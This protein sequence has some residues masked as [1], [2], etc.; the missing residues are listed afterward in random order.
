V[1]VPSRIRIR[2]SGKL[3]SR[4]VDVR[5]EGPLAGG[6]L[7]RDGRPQPACKLLA[8]L[9]ASASA[10]AL[11]ASGGHASLLTGGPVRFRSR[12]EL[13]DERV[14]EVASVVATGTL[15]AHDKLLLCEAEVVG[16]C[17]G[18]DADR[19]L[20]AS[21][22]SYWPREDGVGGLALWATVPVRGGGAEHA[23]DLSMRLLRLASAQVS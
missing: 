11:A 10:P 21:L 3:G 6:D 13:L 19:E 5:H 15:R 17:G 14:G 23:A 20:E 12:L 7:L 1:L 8:L 18:L 22:G 4:A 2:V 9:A 16:D